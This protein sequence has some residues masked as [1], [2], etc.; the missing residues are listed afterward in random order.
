MKYRIVNKGKLGF[1]ITAKD[2]WSER[3]LVWTDNFEQALSYLERLKRIE[4]D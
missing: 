4:N 2:F 3:Y 1:A